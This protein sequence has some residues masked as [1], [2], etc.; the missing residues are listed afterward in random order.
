MEDEPNH[1]TLNHDSPSIQYGDG[2]SG[3][4]GHTRKQIGTYNFSILT[5]SQ[6]SSFSLGAS[7]FNF[8][9]ISV[10]SSTDPTGESVSVTYTIKPGKS[11]I[12]EHSERRCFGQKDDTPMSVDANAVLHVSIVI[13]SDGVEFE[14]DHAT[15]FYKASTGSHSAAPHPPVAPL[16]PTTPFPSAAPAPQTQPQLQLSPPSVD[17]GFVATESVVTHDPLSAPTTTGLSVLLSSTITSRYGGIDTQQTEDVTKGLDPSQR[18]P[19]GVAGSSQAPAPYPSSA[20]DITPIPN[21][22]NTRTIGASS[23]PPYAPAD[24]SSSTASHSHST[25][26]GAIIGGVLG[27]LILPILIYLLWRWHKKRSPVAPSTAYLRSLP[28]GYPSGSRRGYG[29]PILESHPEGMDTT[30][31]FEEHR[32]GAS[33][34]DSDSRYSN[35][36]TLS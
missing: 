17:V 16:P 15:I 23:G 2:W 5:E 20:P 12:L 35:A 1:Y 13:G 3:N 30:G 22:S 27:L 21:G 18:T 7:T 34:S 14:F 36:S 10:C 9:G 19:Q 8:F 28:G 4:S 29:E 31:L 24:T 26:T 6:S 25:P 32:K 11:T 33:E